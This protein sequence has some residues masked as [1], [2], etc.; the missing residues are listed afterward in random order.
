[1]IHADIT[2]AVAAERLTDRLRAATA[3]RLGAAA[4]CCQ[5]TAWQRAVGDARRSLAALVP[6]RPGHGQAR[7]TTAGPGVACC[8]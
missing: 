1:M 7:S 8:A 4:R 3:S 2:A 5:P 6:H